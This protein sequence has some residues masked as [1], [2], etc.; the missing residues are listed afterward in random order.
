MHNVLN[1]LASNRDRFVDLN[2][3]MEV[4]M[5]QRTDANDTYHLLCPVWHD[6]LMKP[7]QDLGICFLLR[8]VDC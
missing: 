8:T 3:R 6:A 2:D 5:G 7:L 4:R 1:P